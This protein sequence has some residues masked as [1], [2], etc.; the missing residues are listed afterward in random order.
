MSSRAT[1]MDTALVTGG[2]RGIGLALAREFARNGHDLVLVAREEAALERAASRLERETGVHVETRTANLTDPGEVERLV[3][4][5][6][7]DGIAVDGLV[8]NAGIGDHAPLAES[9]PDRLERLLQLNVLGLTRLT[10]RL[11]PD[12]LSRGRGRILNVASLVAYFQGGPNWATYVASK[13]YVL[14]FTRGLAMELRGTGVSATALAP[15]ST[16]TEFVGRS[17]VGDVRAYRWLPKVSP[18]RLARAAYDGTMAGRTTVIPGALN[19]LLAFLGELHPRRAAQVVFTFLS[20]AGS[21][22][23]GSQAGSSRTRDTSTRDH[24]LRPVRLWRIHVHPAVGTGWRRP[25]RRSAA[26]R[27]R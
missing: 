21:P 1:D 7:D 27:S 2:S 14:S 3:R 17:G 22:R 10:R 13:A 25:P 4:G 24:R 6:E 26:S 8:S 5:L 16:D 11:L 19:R 12:M 23:L 15:G 18:E 9:D 20:G